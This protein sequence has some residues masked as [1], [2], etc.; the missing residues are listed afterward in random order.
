MAVDMERI[1]Q[2]IKEGDQDS[3]QAQLQEYN[4]QYSEC[5]F[6]NVEEKERRKSLAA[7]LIRFIR[8]QLQP[9]VLIVCLRSLRILS[10]D[11]QALAPLVTDMA[12]LTLARYGGITS[13]PLTLEEDRDIELYTYVNNVDISAI[14]VQN[15]T[16][17]GPRAEL[18]AAAP[19]ATNIKTDTDSP[20]MH[21]ATAAVTITKTQTQSSP[22]AAPCAETFPS[23]HDGKAEDVDKT[24]RHA[25]NA[26]G[27]R[28]GSHHIDANSNAESNTM[29]ALTEHDCTNTRPDAHSVLTRGKRDSGREREEEDEEGQDEREVWRKEAMKALCNIIYNSQKAQER[30]S[31]L[32]LL[33]G[34]SERLKKGTQ[35]P[36]PSSSQFYELR[37]LFLLTALRPELRA[38]L[39][40]ERGVSMLTTA[41]EQCLEV[42][43]G[44]EYEVLIDPTARPVSKEVSQRAMEILKTLFNITYSV[45]RQ[46]PDEEDAAL[47]RHLA[48]V[49]RHCLLLLCDGEERTEELQ[50]HTVNV[51]SALPLQCL[52]VLLSV[53]LSEGSREWEGV[54]MDCVHT[55]LVFMQKRLDRG[56][57]EKLTPVLN[58]LMESSRAHKETRHYLRQQILPPLR[59][60]ANRPE[61]GPTV[62]GQLVRLMTHVDTDI[63]YCSAELLF[64][65]CKENVSRF[66]KYTGYGNAAGLLAAW[67]LLSGGSRVGARSAVGGQYSSDSDSDT[68]EYRQAKGRINPVT[69]R[70]EEE[71]P[72]PMEGMTE[73]EKEEEARKLINMFNRLSH[74]NIIQPMGVTTDGRLAPLSGQLRDCTLEEERESEGGS[75]E[76]ID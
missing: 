44:E 32:R 31:I 59:D 28:S 55:L 69:G 20:S 35:A 7:A 24:D 36:E 10:R 56:Q 46:K 9:G 39:H 65:L 57:K 26:K 37:L 68:E 21:A 34:L 13:F 53:R 50:G 51:L 19:A 45:R 30:A 27:T 22:N 71:Q 8:M 33:S 52:D 72:D 5:F 61:Q 40:Q 4:I 66:V 6:F 1:I 75:E 76:E 41:L 23:I 16:K 64:V 67:G 47:Y 15:D 42:Q 43:W 63:K 62:R 73:E 11:R 49:L 18:N 48:A 2:C 3:V 38:Q 17:S 29:E 58:L 74:D 70:V 60:V 14:D 25:K 12:L 54:N